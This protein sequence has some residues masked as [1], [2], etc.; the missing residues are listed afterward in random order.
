M[1]KLSSTK[2][3][4]GLKSL[5]VAVQLGTN[6]KAKNY[7][8]RTALHL[9]ACKRID[10]NIGKESF[11]SR[12]LDFLLQ[13][14]LGIPISA[15][16]NNGVT[17]L[18]LA[19]ACSDAMFLQLFLAGADIRAKDFR[20]RT[21]LHFA[22]ANLSNTTG[23][24]C[25]IYHQNGW[26]VDELDIKGRTPLFEACSAGNYEA[27]KFLLENGANVLITDKLRRTP[28]HAAAKYR[29]DS[30]MAKS[31]EEF[32]TG[33]DNSSRFP[34]GF[35]QRRKG[36]GDQKVI[37]LLQTML[38]GENSQ[39][40]S[41]NIIR[42]LLNFGADPAEVDYLDYTPYDLALLNS[43]DNIAHLLRLPPQLATLDDSEHQSHN[44]HTI[45]PKWLPLGAESTEGIKFLSVNEIIEHGYLEMAIYSRS[46]PLLTAFLKSGV[47]L[48]HLRKTEDDLTIIHAVVS[49]GMIS[50]MKIIAPYISDINEFYPPLLHHAV[51]REESNLE[52]M[53]L[54]L[55]LGADLNA[56][57]PKDCDLE[58]HRRRWISGIIPPSRERNTVLHKLS[59]GW[60]W[61]YSKAID[62]L[63]K[64]GADL[65]IKDSKGETAL[66]IA[67]SNKVGFWQNQCLEMLLSKGADVN[68][69]HEKS[70][71]TVLN[72][73]L[74]SGSGMSIVQKLLTHGANV[75]LG[76]NPP[77]ISAIEGGDIE[78]LKL[79]LDAGADP[80]GLYGPQKESPL[81]TVANQWAFDGGPNDEK[82]F[83][84]LI[85]VL[86]TAGAD[87]YGEV[88]CWEWS[89]TRVFHV[90]CRRNAMITP[91][92]DFG[93][94]LEVRD[95]S[96]RTPL[97]A[98]CSYEGNQPQ[99][100]VDWVAFKLLELD[101]EIDVMDEKGDTPLLY[102]AQLDEDSTE[103]FSALLKSGVSVNK[104][105]MEG[106]TA[107]YYIFNRSGHD[108]QI[109][110]E[111]PIEELMT[112]GADPTK[113]TFEGEPTNLHMLAKAMAE[114][115]PGKDD[116]Y[117]HS[118]DTLSQFYQQ[119]IE[120][121]CNSEARDDEGNTPVFYFVKNLA[122]QEKYGGKAIE[123]SIAHCRSFFEKCNLDTVNEDLDNILHA[124][125]RLPSSHGTDDAPLFRLL[126]EMGV[127]P[128]HENNLG[129][130]PLDMAAA[131][132]KQS[133]LDIFER[134][135]Q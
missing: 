40:Q 43:N 96:G 83:S 126:M 57:Y 98:A 104:E 119:F 112:R 124:V 56:K 23:M 2:I 111:Y 1:E 93:I 120:L 42:T 81:L 89:S 108:V 15:Q 70:G 14:K 130:S 117:T 34:Q 127:D 53:K 85:T 110:I 66:H 49:S 74:K 91:F 50:M 102:R 7:S 4:S 101:V 22:A 82:A 92:L 39:N 37:R 88:S 52:M 121:G 76:T 48:S 69:I 115:I 95:R 20:N 125:A 77:L 94:D 44:T 118:Y 16:D 24:I 73:A 13:P 28:L 131:C 75:D 100:G 55:E 84:K 114:I 80:N 107:L 3:S 128:K 35:Y 133:I 31:E 17:A 59:H 26:S 116:K 109:D 61:W 90:F 79:L 78:G 36:N 68:A 132:G 41:Q 18:H 135:T 46:E 113:G 87:P 32:Y 97:H 25:D 86:L 58:K 33:R 11:D 54:L 62:L 67:V 64:A 103:I 29:Q 21:P 6:C 65:E 19:A 27:V 123:P 105:N 38:R 30:F 47:D 10:S 51:V 122:R 12:R 99:G 9:A 106:R 134:E 72:M 71:N 45:A 129:I 8:G 63:A 5:E 60:C